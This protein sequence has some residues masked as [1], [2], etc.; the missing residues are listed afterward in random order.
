MKKALLKRTQRVH[1]GEAEDLLS[2]SFFNEELGQVPEEEK[3][4]EEKKKEEIK[5]R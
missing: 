3:D 1:F 5:S 2:T 4:E